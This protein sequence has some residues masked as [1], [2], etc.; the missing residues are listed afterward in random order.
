PLIKSH[1]TLGSCLDPSSAS[2][3]P[4]IT[5]FIHGEIDF[6]NIMLP[7]LNDTQAP[8]MLHTK[9]YMANTNMT[10]ILNSLGMHDW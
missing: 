1:M 4:N 2:Y 5:G 10:E 6:H 7:S 3:F 8:W 9:S